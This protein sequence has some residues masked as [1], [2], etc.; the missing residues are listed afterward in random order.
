MELKC[1]YKDILDQIAKIMVDNYIQDT[2]S[3]RDEFRNILEAVSTIIESYID[4]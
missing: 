2:P 3:S 4:E 1:H